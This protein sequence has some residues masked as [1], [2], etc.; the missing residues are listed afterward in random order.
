MKK[1]IITI[2]V[3]IIIAVAVIVPVWLFVS[4]VVQNNRILKQYQII[5]ATVKTVEANLRVQA[6]REAPKAEEKK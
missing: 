2:A 1:Q 3:S 5:D 4:T 6:Q